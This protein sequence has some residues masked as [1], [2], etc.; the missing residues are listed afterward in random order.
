MSGL[1]P[2]LRRIE[3]GQKEKCQFLLKLRDRLRFVLRSI[4]GARH[5]ARRSLQSED[6]CERKAELESIAGASAQEV[7]NVRCLEDQ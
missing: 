1:V 5:G 6:G 7:S 3:R 4:Q 2:G